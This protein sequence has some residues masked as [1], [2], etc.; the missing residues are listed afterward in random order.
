MSVFASFVR[1]AHNAGPQRCLGSA[2]SIGGSR[3]AHVLG[4]RGPTMTLDTACS[5]TQSQSG[6][7]RNPFQIF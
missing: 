6:D 1:F 3:L 2:Q 4:L 5:G 7:G